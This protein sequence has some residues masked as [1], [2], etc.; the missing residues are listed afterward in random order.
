M[1]TTVDEDREDDDEFREDID[2]DEDDLLFETD[3]TGISA[4]DLLGE[5]FEREAAS[6]G[7][8]LAH[9]S[10]VLLTIV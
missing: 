7:M 2:D 8:F 3:V 4:W 1:N 10:S 6:I 9:I 5:G